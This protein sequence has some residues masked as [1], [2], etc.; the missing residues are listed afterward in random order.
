M[1]TYIK[2][3]RIHPDKRECWKCTH[4]CA[5]RTSKYIDPS[6]EKAQIEYNED[7][8]DLAERDAQLT[9]KEN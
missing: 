9:G 3:A 1:R 8:R 2:C 6:L 5:I 7:M 4:T